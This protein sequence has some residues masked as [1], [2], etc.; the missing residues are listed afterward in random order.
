MQTSKT[1]TLYT[2]FFIKITIRLALFIDLPPGLAILPHSMSLSSYVTEAKRDPCLFY[3][4]LL[5]SDSSDEFVSRDPAL[6]LIILHPVVPSSSR[7]AKVFYHQDS[8][9]FAT[10]RRWIKRQAPVLFADITFWLGRQREL[11]SSLI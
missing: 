5:D 8:A 9:S 11:A 7:P 10:S 3:P 1:S 6:C 2:F 4:L